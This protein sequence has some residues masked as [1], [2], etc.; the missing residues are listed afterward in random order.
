ML[1]GFSVSNSTDF[2]PQFFAVKGCM[3]DILSSLSNNK[4]LI[5]LTSVLQINH[6]KKVSTNQSWVLSEE[7]E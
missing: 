5:K 2:F 6:Y 4:I 7:A 3:Q 1:S